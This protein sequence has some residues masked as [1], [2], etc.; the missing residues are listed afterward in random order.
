MRTQQA[1]GHAQLTA[2]RRCDVLDA[3]TVRKITR[4][5]ELSWLLDLD[6]EHGLIVK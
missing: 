4:E 5:V 3:Y 2:A 6:D 1:A